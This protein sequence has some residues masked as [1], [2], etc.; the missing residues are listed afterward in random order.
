[1]FNTVVFQQK[2][3]GSFNR[4]DSF[5]LPSHLANT[6]ELMQDK[7]LSSCVHIPA[8]IFVPKTFDEFSLKP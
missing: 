2:R 5:L 8:H 6:I 1:M 4:I 7:Y 3:Q